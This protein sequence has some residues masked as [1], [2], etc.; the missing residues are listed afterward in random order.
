MLGR[1]KTRE[2]TK[3]RLWLDFAPKQPLS[4]IQDS[5]KPVGA[6]PSPAWREREGEKGRGRSGERATRAVLQ[7]G[8]DNKEKDQVEE[9]EEEGKKREKSTTK[10]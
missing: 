5:S 7:K 10:R 8:G 4:T 3:E 1:K 2:R 9:D 6:D